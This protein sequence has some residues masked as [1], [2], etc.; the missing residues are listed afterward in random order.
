VIKTPFKL[1]LLSIWKKELDVKEKTTMI[2][3]GNQAYFVELA[4]RG[5]QEG[6]LKKRGLNNTCEV[7]RLVCVR[8]C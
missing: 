5:F 6:V 4:T 8:V 7:W 1:S 3:N 2:I